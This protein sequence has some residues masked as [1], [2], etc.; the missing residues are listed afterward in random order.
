MATCSLFR[1]RVQLHIG[2]LFSD[3]YSRFYLENVPSEPSSAY[4]HAIYFIFVA[5]ESSD[6][7]KAQQELER[8]V[9]LQ[10]ASDAAPTTTHCEK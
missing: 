4:S 1:V 7:K 10:S 9:G 3:L 6:Y 8:I 5:G 2:P